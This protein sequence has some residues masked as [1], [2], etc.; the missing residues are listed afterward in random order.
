M[1]VWFQLRLTPKGDYTRTEITA[2][3]VLNVHAA[4]LNKWYQSGQWLSV[5]NTLLVRPKSA[6]YT[7]K[8]D[9]EYPCHFYMGVSPG[10]LSDKINED[11]LP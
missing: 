8:Q 9:D 4:T 11:P 2:I 3:F 7:P 6:I 5:P 1:W 10:Q